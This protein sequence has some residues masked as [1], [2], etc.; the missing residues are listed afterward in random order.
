MSEDDNKKEKVTKYKSSS[1]DNEKPTNAKDPYE[2]YKAVPWDEKEFD[3]GPLGDENRV[4][5]DCVCC[6]IFVVFLASCVYVAIYSFKNGDPN[7]HYFLHF[8]HFLHFL[9]H[10]LFHHFHYLIHYFFFYD[11]IRLKL[12]ITLTKPFPKSDK[13]VKKTKSKIKIGAI[14]PIIPKK[15][16]LKFIYNNNDFIGMK[17]DNEL[18]SYRENNNGNIK[19]MIYYMFI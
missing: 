14:T 17:N 15:E 1:N 7:Y 11:C 3:N 2:K 5:R 6:I 10:L 12:S 9:L 8:R 16:E 13:R 19:M 4:C 18:N